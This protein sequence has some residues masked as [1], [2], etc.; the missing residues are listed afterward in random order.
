MGNGLVDFA[1]G[2]AV[3]AAPQHQVPILA[4]GAAVKLVRLLRGRRKDARQAEDAARS[5]DGGAAEQVTLAWEHVSCSL[6]DKHGK[7]KEILKDLSGTARPGR[8]LALMG[9]SGSGKTTLLNAL[10]G[11]VPF[12]KRM[13]LEGR[14]TMNGQPAATAAFR[15]GYVQQEDIFYSQL[16]VRETLMMAA[17]LRMGDASQGSKEALVERLISRLG[18][19]KA[20]D[21][22]VGDK[23]TRGL[24]GG[25]KK[26]LSIGCELIASP[27]LVFAD[28]ATT[29]LDAFQAEQVMQ[30]L[31][32][33]A[34]DGHT[35]VA[36]IHQP[37]SS[38]FAM[39]DDLVLLSE[40]GLVYSGPAAD[41]LDYF[42]SLGHKCPSHYNPAEFLADLISIDY[43]SP[44]SEAST[45]ARSAKLQA[46]WR[47][48]HTS[49]PAASTASRPASATS[50]VVPFVA[51]GRPCGWPRQAQ[52]L[53]SRSWR[54]ISRDRATNI[55]RAMTNINSAFVFG[56]IFWQLKRTQTAIQDRMGLL[57]VCAI[58]TAMSS[59]IKTL[60]VFPTERVIVER[61][62][63]KK[64]YHVLPYFVS[65]L[66]AESPIGAM[67]P[68]LFASIVYPAAR[69][70]PSPARFGR[71]LG[72]LTLESFVSSS[73]GLAVGAVAPSTEAALAL[74]PA[75][76]LVFIVFGGYYVNGENVPRALQWLPKTSFIKHAFQGLCVNEFEG[77]EFE[78]A[79]AGLPVTTG[80]QVLDR[81][82]F[83]DRSVGQAALS[84]GRI[85]LFNYWLTYCILKAKKPRY[86][87]M[88]TPKAA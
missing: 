27:T 55:T 69:L 86:L 70:N 46:A 48:P 16:T 77:L 61:E 67:F 78:A 3:I 21:T 2:A 76:I 5:S 17:H 24:S 19:A 23:K 53:F 11:Q 44:E 25:E 20:A 64:S 80:Q 10:S 26:R 54:Q 1:L 58:N 85:L 41:A 62:R 87:T 47:Q 49:T 35:V 22:V 8:L 88:E 15:Q 4:G 14:L 40:G 30:T 75:V 56:A 29:G 37:R 34:A 12:A 6:T 39:F 63:T 71:F 79:K 73:L 74:G 28:E 18:L 45:R 38:I 60:N 59:L 36:S 13:H 33:L 57:Q 7:T 72:L 83:Y 42:A 82:S 51:S 9:P 65:K 52:L 81:Y 31:K 50:Q 68:L 84:Q 66:V 43:S 32:D